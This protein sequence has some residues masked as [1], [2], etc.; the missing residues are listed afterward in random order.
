MQTALS[1]F[2]H[3]SR[4]P[5]SAAIAE[6]TRRKWFIAAREQKQKREE[7]EERA[8]E[9]LLDLAIA[10]TLATETLIEAF[11]VKLDNY[12]EATVRALMEN[13]KA[14]DAVQVEIDD[15]LSRAHKLEDGRA[16]FKTEDG[17]KVFD[18]HGAQLEET[19][20]HPDSISDE[21]PTWESYNAKR[22]GRDELL[23]ERQEIFDYQ[24][25]LDEA[26]EHANSGEMT[27]DELT[28]LE[29]ELEADM[30]P[31]VQR[32]L[33]DYE[34]VQQTSLTSDFSATAR[35]MAISTVAPTQIPIAPGLGQ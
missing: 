20:I 35:D 13:Q 4:K 1:H 30:P 15:M 6:A 31:A 8:E 29:A 18:Q 12:D 7:M 33:P 11:N 24:E 27:Q 2:Q 5:N 9:A 17:T 34:P 19:T 14:L 16:V 23:K 26:R 3:Y 25:K 22:E 32:Q 28:E 10:V 21:A